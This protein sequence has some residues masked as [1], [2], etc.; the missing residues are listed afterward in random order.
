MRGNNLCRRARLCQRTANLAR[1]CFSPNLPPQKS[2]RLADTDP[3]CRF[4]G[5]LIE[6]QSMGSPRHLGDLPAQPDQPNFGM[7]CPL[8]TAE[9][10]QH[11]Q[12]HRKVLTAEDAG[13]AELLEIGIFLC[14][15]SGSEPTSQVP[16]AEDPKID[17][18][19]PSARFRLITVS[20]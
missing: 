20:E 16:W 4:A 1:R 18:F 13:N 14:A 7:D 3:K 19:R 11:R 9:D 2:V 12:Q 15:L 5:F 8:G 17:F 6:P 10:Q